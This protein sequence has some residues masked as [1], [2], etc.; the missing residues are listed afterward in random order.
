MIIVG[1]VTALGIPRECSHFFQS[2]K[3]LLLRYL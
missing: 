3:F 2:C 1:K